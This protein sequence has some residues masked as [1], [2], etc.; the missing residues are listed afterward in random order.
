MFDFPTFSKMLCRVLLNR[1]FFSAVVSSATPSAASIPDG[2]L[3]RVPSLEP[4]VSRG[5]KSWK[6]LGIFLA[7]NVIP[8]GA[9]YVYFSAAIEA[10]E[11]ELDAFQALPNAPVDLIISEVCLVTKSADTCLLLSCNSL[12]SS[13]TPHAPEDQTLEMISELPISSFKYDPLVDVLTARYVGDASPLTSIHF[14]VPNLSLAT[15]GDSPTLIYSSKDRGGLVTVT[16]EWEVV[17]DE[18]MRDYYWRNRWGSKKDASLVKFKPLKVSLQSSR[19]PEDSI[20]RM[21]C[22]FR[23][24][25]W[26]KEIL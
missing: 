21:V 15:L 1:R 3:S 18:R 5:F 24:S 26:R 7:A 22:I 23:D 8:I 17:D 14:A 6:T 4:P 11:K 9:A 19:K 2:S 20:P 10:R 13:I 16:G 12:I 25:K